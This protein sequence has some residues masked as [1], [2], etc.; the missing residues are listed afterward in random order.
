MRKLKDIEYNY[1]ARE[2][3]LHSIGW[4][5]GYF[6]LYIYSRPFNSSMDATSVY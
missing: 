3:H 5:P 1:L 2:S 4:R 6:H